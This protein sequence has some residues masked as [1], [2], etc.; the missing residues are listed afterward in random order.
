MG[1]I[2]LMGGRTLI[3]RSNLRSR[4]WGSAVSWAGPGSNL[5][6]ALVIA[7]VLRIG[8]VDP[9]SPLGAGL[10][11][12][13]VL[14]IAAAL[15]N[16]IPVPPLDGFGALAPHLNH[17]TQAKAYSFG[18]LGYFAILILMWNVPAFG[19]AFWN[20]AYRVA[21]AFHIPPNPV[22]IG[23]FFSRLR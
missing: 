22:Y 1:G 20:E 17:E 11:Y 3:D 13:A 4:W 19:G 6:E 16:M 10:A 9:Y 23:W 7:C 8:I 12:L 21:D 15:F 18:Y 14:E 2:P 5:L